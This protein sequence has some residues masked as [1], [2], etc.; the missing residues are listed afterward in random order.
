M[1][2]ESIRNLVK[3]GKANC[4]TDRDTIAIANKDEQTI[5]KQMGTCEEIKSALMLNQLIQLAKHPIFNGDWEADYTNDNQSKY[6]FYICD[7][8]LC[9]DTSNL[10]TQKISF[11][12]CEIRSKFREFVGDEKII[13]ALS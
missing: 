7:N 5:L 8:N 4:L 1:V 10:I 9:N 13:L 6:C 2:D 11:K 3:S 12:S